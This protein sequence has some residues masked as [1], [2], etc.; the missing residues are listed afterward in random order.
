MWY[1]GAMKNIIQFMVTEEDG[2]YTADGVNVPVVTEG[3]SFEELQKN[4]RDAVTLY[5]S[6]DDH[7]SLGFGRYPSILTNFE[8]SPLYEG[9]A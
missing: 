6:G 9:S 1:T 8:L 4:I 7:A 3:S 2:V 5:F